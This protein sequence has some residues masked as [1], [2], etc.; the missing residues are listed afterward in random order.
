MI[1][2][3]VYETFIIFNA[4][5]MTF[6][7]AEIQAVWDLAK[8]V[9]GKVPSMYRY[10]PYR[11]PI[12]RRSYGKRSSQGWSIDHIIATANGGPHILSNWQALFWETNCKKQDSEVKKSRHSVSNQ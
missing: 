4:D 11:T 5:H 8:T 2:V 10:D 3:I 9:D 6:T 12:F 1:K 7:E